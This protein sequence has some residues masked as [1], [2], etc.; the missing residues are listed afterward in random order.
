M[1][2]KKQ[3]VT[4]VAS[5]LPIVVRAVPSQIEGAVVGYGGVNHDPAARAKFRR[6]AAINSRALEVLM[7]SPA[8]LPIKVRRYPVKVDALE[9]RRK[10]RR[11]QKPHA[12][13]SIPH[14][15]NG[16]C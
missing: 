7:H 15:H 3:V 12:A 5:G 8:D 9:E 4:S 16:S 13:A 14:K 11:G 6:V 2:K 1:S 10:V